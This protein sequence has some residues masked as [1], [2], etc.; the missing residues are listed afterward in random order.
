MSY[1]VT[2]KSSKRAKALAAVFYDVARNGKLGRA[3]IIAREEG[4][5]GYEAWKKAGQDGMRHR[6]SCKNAACPCKLPPE[7]G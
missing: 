5:L 7:N 1:Y 3:S 4:R 6:G 2:D